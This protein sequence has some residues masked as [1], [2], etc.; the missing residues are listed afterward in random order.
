MM[1]SFFWETP[2]TLANLMAPIQRFGA[3]LGFK[4]NW[5]KSTLLPL[6]PLTLPLPQIAGQIKIVDTFKYLGI[7]IHPNLDTY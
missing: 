7:D 6:D 1:R 3:F 4:I 2:L 5:E